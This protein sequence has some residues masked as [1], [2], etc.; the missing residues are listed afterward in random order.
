MRRGRLCYDEVAAFAKLRTATVN[1][2][3][4]VRP[5]ALLSARNSSAPLE[6]GGSL[7]FC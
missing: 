6:G 1:F 2:V 5:S 4:S 3:M 7:M